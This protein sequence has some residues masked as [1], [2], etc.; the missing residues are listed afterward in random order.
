MNGNI[1]SNSSS[2]PLS[3]AIINSDGTVDCHEHHVDVLRTSFTD[4]VH[5][6]A[7]L[8]PD[9]KNNGTVKRIQQ[10]PLASF[11]LINERHCHNW[12]PTVDFTE[13]AVAIRQLV[14]V[15]VLCFLFMSA[16]IIGKLL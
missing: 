4:D 8:V 13:D 12:W 1:F 7:P 15:S 2:R 16:Q 10:H 14:F 11:P 6:T 9:D 3:P 5:E